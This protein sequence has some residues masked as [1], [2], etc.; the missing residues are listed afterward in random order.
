M[1]KSQY[2]RVFYWFVL[3]SLILIPNTYAI[4]NT[5]NIDR[6]NT[7]YTDTI[8]DV[9]IDDWIIWGN[10]KG[11]EVVRFL[12]VVAQPIVIIVFIV[13]A[14]MVLFGSIGRGDLSG[15]GMWGMVVSAI[16]HALILYAPLLLQTF[17]GWVS[18]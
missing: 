12:Q 9:T 11:F 10:R 18:A 13:S 6:I 4:E 5:S 16:V 15:K 8:P 1:F 14:F 3:F 17:V 7:S 2:I